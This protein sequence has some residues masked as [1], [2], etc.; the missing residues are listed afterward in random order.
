MKTKIILLSVLAIFSIGTPIARAQEIERIDVYENTPSSVILHTVS[1]PD[2]QG[3]KLLDSHDSASFR[4]GGES[5]G[6]QATTGTLTFDTSPPDYESPEDTATSTTPSAVAGDNIYLFYIETDIIGEGD[7]IAP[8]VVYVYNMEAPASPTDFEETSPGTVGWTASAPPPSTLTLN[9]N[10]ITILAVSYDAVDDITYDVDYRV[11]DG[12]DSWTSGAMDTSDTQVTLPSSLQLSNMRY[13]VR[14]RAE[15]LEGSSDYATIEIGEITPEMVGAPT[16]TPDPTNPNTRLNVSWAAPSGTATITAYNIQYRVKDTGSYRDASYSGTVRSH[17]LTGL[18]PGTTYQV[19]VRAQSSAGTG[20]WSTPGEGT[21]ETPTPPPPPP[22]KPEAPSAPVVQLNANDPHNSLLVQWTPPTEQGSPITNY[23]VQYKM[24]S[25]SA[26]REHPHEGTETST[27]LSQLTPG[28]IY[29]ARVRATTANGEVTPWSPPGEGTTARRR[30]KIFV[31]PVGWQR[32]TPFGSLT[33]RVLIRAVELEIDITNITSIYKVSA[34]EIYADPDENL[35]DLDGWKLT[36]ARLYNYGTDYLL[37]AENSAL[38]ED[39]FARIESPADAPF[40]I[41]D[42]SFSGQRL[43]GFDYR[44]FDAEG[45]RVDFG[46][47]C[48]KQGGLTSR[49]RAMETPRVERLL[50]IARLAWQTPYYRSEWSVPEDK[51]GTAAA[52]STV[53]KDPVSSWAALKAEMLK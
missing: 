12:G 19:Q 24:K 17:T 21:T 29:Q 37:T 27:I 36:L 5:P 41:T 14:V 10:T 42:A 48:Y 9:G 45:G 7:P 32:H 8:F 44:L 51:P 31:C 38:D 40:P 47:S 26:W 23:D 16:V 30:V 4:I 46:I 22:P 15:N 39:G 20:P 11:K 18:N 43:P 6:T 50:D 35:S 52:P 53:R 34:I 33:K 1:H 49:L 2:A 13:E 25:Q 3:Y 28:I